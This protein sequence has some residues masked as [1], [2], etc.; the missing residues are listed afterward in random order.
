[1]S[2][3]YPPGPPG[4]FLLGHLLQYRRQRLQFLLNGARRYGDIFT[5][6]VPTVR[7]YILNHPDLIEDVLV[8]RHRLFRKHRTFDALRPLLGEGLLTSEGDFWRRQRKLMQPAFHQQRLAEYA[9]IMTAQAGR[10]MELWEGRG[11]LDLHAELMALTLEI[12]CECLFSTQVSNHVQDVSRSLDVMMQRFE[13]YLHSVFRANW[14]PTP[15]RLRYQRE[16][17]RLNSIIFEIIQR[18]REQGDDQ[19]DLLSLLL[20]LRDEDGQGMTDRQ[21]KDEAMTLF[22]AG[23]ETTANA[24][25][26]SWHLLAG[27][28]GVEEKLNEELDRVLEGRPPQLSDL[29][30]LAYT[31]SIV[32]ESMRLYPPAYF[33]GRLAIEP[34]TLGG[35]DLAAGA[36]VGMSPFVAHRDP[37]FWEGP[38]EFRPERWMSGE[39]ED[40]PKFAYFPFGGGP[41]VCIGNAFAMMESILLLAMIGQRCKFAPLSEREVV[42]WPSVTLRPKGGLWMEIIQRPLRKGQPAESRA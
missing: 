6:K 22:V 33:I 29:A 12:V 11:L 32:K 16:I 41:R 18:R 28:P 3:R 5:L 25:A 9:R 21:I 38:E 27:H 37:R 20:D 30:R 23:H 10:R 7:Y 34:L 40:L 17:E 36:T 14:I 42:V 4:N 39:C 24:L 31:E 26:W 8:R 15:G 1:M 2:R 13:K 19:G 35:Y